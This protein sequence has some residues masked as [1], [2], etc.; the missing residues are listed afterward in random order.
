MKKLLIT[1][2]LVLFL[3]IVFLQ[4]GVLPQYVNYQQLKAQLRDN[5]RMLQAKEDHFS[6]LFT[7]KS[8]L[9]NYQSAFAKMSSAL[10]PATDSAALYKFVEEKANESGLMVRGIGG[11]SISEAGE[12]YQGKIEFGMIVGGSYSALTNFLKAVEN[13]SR[14]INV[15]QVSLVSLEDEE[16]EEELSSGPFYSISLTAY[17]APS[18]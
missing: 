9:G 5:E 15:G 13:S 4:V 16:E 17:Y 3:S 2:S 7:I 11:L 18:S 14:L 12:S 1:S 8:K 6:Q 10:P